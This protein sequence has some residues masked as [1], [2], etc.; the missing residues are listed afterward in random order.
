MTKEMEKTTKT[1]APELFFFFLFLSLFPLVFSSCHLYR[2]G[3][4]GRLFF[5]L[6]SYAACEWCHTPQCYLV[7]LSAAGLVASG[8]PGVMSV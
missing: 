6:L 2:F 1:R 3:A 8:V 7:S 5:F 4:R